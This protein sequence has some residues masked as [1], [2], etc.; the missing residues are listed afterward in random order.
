MQPGLVFNYITLYLLDAVV[1]PLQLLAVTL[2]FVCIIAGVVLFILFYLI[3]RTGRSMR[4]RSLREQY[5]NCISELA[6]CETDE[7]LQSFLQQPDTQRITRLLEHEAFSRRVIITELLKTVK[8]MS[9]NAATNVCWFYEQANLQHD[10]LLRLQNGAWHVKARAIQELSGLRQNKYITKIYRH[11]NNANELVRNEARTAVVKLTGF[12]G[13]R[14][15]DVATYPLTEWQQLCLLYEL[16]LHSN[17]SFEGVQRWLQSS[18]SSVTEFALRLVEVYHLHACFSTVTSCLKHAAKPVRKKALAALKEIYDPAINEILVAMF[19][20]EDADV[21]ILILQ[22]LKEFGTEEEQAFLLQQLLHE[23]QEIKVA[24]ARAVY[25][26]QPDAESLL[27]QRVQTD[28]YPWNVLLVQLKQE[29]L[30]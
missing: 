15:L 19:P 9:G 27:R 11:T 26:T 22:M 2:F 6:V 18:N 17:R 7:E 14:F 12:E 3:R 28:T 21:Q 8:N 16:S 13:L 5:S 10:S 20:A 1:D 4:R 30:L 29:V 24:A 25:Y 23:Q